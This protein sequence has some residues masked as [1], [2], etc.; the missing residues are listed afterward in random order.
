MISKRS[1]SNFIGEIHGILLSKGHRLKTGAY[2]EDVQLLDDKNVATAK[3][4]DPDSQKQVQ[5]AL[6]YDDLSNSIKC[7][8]NCPSE[9]T[10][11]HGAG[12]ALF[13]LENFSEVET[14]PSFHSHGFDKT[15]ACEWR[16]IPIS[17]TADIKMDLKKLI[18]SPKYGAQLIFNTSFLD[19][20]NQLHIHFISPYHGARPIEVFFAK[21]GNVHTCKCTDCPEKTRYFCTHASQAIEVIFRNSSI[22]KWFILPNLFESI[23]DHF[24]EKYRLPKSLLETDFKV[25]FDEQEIFLNVVDGTFF[26][27]S[28]ESLVKQNIKRDKNTLKP[29]KSIKPPGEY[30]QAFLW[31]QLEHTEKNR[32]FGFIE[33]KLSKDRS[34]MINSFETIVFPKTWDSSMKATLLEFNLIDFEHDQYDIAYKNQILEALKTNLLRIREYTHF[35][36]QGTYLKELFQ[37]Y[38]G[39]QK[40][41]RKDLE[42]FEFAPYTCHFEIQLEALGEAMVLAQ[43]YLVTHEA[44]LPIHEADF[45]PY[46]TKIGQTAYLHEHVVSS[47]HIEILKSLIKLYTPTI[48]LNNLVDT[49]LPLESIFK[50]N[51]NDIAGVEFETV[52]NGIQEL[53]IEEHGNIVSFEPKL[54]YGFVDFPL[55]RPTNKRLNSKIIRPTDQD[56]QQYNEVLS[57]INPDFNPDK[58]DRNTYYLSYD[59]LLDGLWFLDFFED[60]KRHRIEVY[61]E[62]NLTKLKFNNHKA[63]VATGIKSNVDWFDVQVDISFGNQKVKLKDWVRA[64]KNKSRYIKLDD[65][66]LGILPEQWYE[67]LRNIY[68]ISEMKSNSIT[69]NKFKFN[70]VETVFEDNEIED[71]PLVHQLIERRE[72]LKTFEKERTYPIPASLKATL[73]PYQWVG[74]Q[75]L[76][77]LDDYK[78]GGIL[79]D[80]MGLGKTL[81]IIAL[82]ADFKEHNRHKPNLVIVPRSLVFNWI[83][84][85]NKFCPDLEVLVH[86]GS[87]RMVDY[88]FFEKYD[89]ILTTYDTAVQDREKLLPIAFHYIILDESQ[90]IKNPQT[91]R[92]QAVTSFKAENRLTMTGTPIENNTF[93]LFAQFSFVIPGILGNITHFKQNYSIPIDVNQDSKAAE[94]LQRIIAPYILRRTK[95]QVAKDLPEKS[96]S[97]IYCEMQPAQQDMYNSLLTKIKNDIISSLDKEQGNSSTSFLAIEGLLRL[98]Q[99]CNSPLLVDPSLKGNK[100]ESSKL[101]VLINILKDDLGQ[102][103]ALVFSQ[104]TKMLS[105]IRERLDALNIPYVY[106]DGSTRNREEVVR[107]FQE[108]DQYKVFLISLKA[109]NTGLNLTKAEYVFLVDPWWNPAVEAQAIDRTHRIGQD[110][111]IM[112]YR[113]ICKN[114]IEEK[115]IKMQ[116]KKKKVA[117]SLIQ[118]DTEVFKSMKQ[119][120]LLALFDL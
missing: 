100:R 14:A 91:K 116:Q 114:S 94:K 13:L 4:I 90:A 41:S 87:K 44:R 64:I 111:H 30:G 84:E 10:C 56:I 67:K 37:P 34:K 18:Q 108:E 62:Q 24:S 86:H 57:T 59:Q 71:S 39:K 74:F 46:F 60:C 50:I 47:W 78:M 38:V 36:F 29:L 52:E 12:L 22:S 54:N 31:H 27:E 76:K 107:Q 88:L 118:S 35:I 9:N 101:D 19:E 55:I 69:I 65:G 33:A 5:T 7:E 17:D 81:Q 45:S 89:V 28:Y 53:Y 82:L 103:S 85:I 106:L 40:L 110:K 66:S 3:I 25:G 42:A 43:A 20:N 102:S 120:D 109:G 32:G 96:E 72:R 117:G 58:T 61:G 80:E 15:T 95:A 99:I 8:C 73:R 48:Y 119:K 104:F 92:F 21:E 23:I 93:D 26:K 49:L 6:I 112:A 2:I 105:L 11:Y 113:M 83:N 77:F 51:W 68:E 70:A 79:A 115:I 75:W 16:T 97:I 1:I 98:R 63:N